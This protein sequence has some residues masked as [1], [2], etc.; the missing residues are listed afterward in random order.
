M[1]VDAWFLV[2]FGAFS[3]V[4]CMRVVSQRL[5][6]S[7][8][9]E[10]QGVG[11]SHVLRLIYVVEVVLMLG[12]LFADRVVILLC[13]DLGISACVS[14]LRASRFLVYIPVVQWRW[15]GRSCDFVWVWYDIFEVTACSAGNRLCSVWF[16]RGFG[17]GVFVLCLRCV[18]IMLGLFVLCGFVG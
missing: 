12:S 7:W 10:V 15:L 17:C 5:A 1:D 4:G 3:H 2:H 6:V 18:G 8:C 14:R 11:V 13:G 16:L 9:D